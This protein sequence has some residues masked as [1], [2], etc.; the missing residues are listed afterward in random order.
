L[1]EGD[2]Q[3]FGIGMPIIAYFS[4]RVTDAST[5]D[6][7]VTVTVNGQ[8]ADGAWYWEPSSLSSEAMEAH[9]R[10]AQ[11]WPGHAVIKVNM[12]LAGLWAGPGLVFDD[13]LTLSM[14]TGPAHL[15]TIDG[16]A[17]VDTM[18]ITSDSD[19]VRTLRVSLGKS[20]TPTYLGT[21]LVMAKDNP[22][23]M[24]SAPGEEPAYRIEV[25]WSVRVTDDGEFIH[26]AYWNGQI[27]QQ[28]LSHG[29]TNLTPADAE[30]YYSWSLIGDP[31]TWINTGTS[32]VIPA[33]DGWGDWNL[34]WTT[35]QQ[36]GL[37][38]PVA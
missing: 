31:V 33:T 19:P 21:A 9:Y 27:G 14:N 1:F 20:S 38:S 26:D 35:W 12:P 36:G 24:V 29:C 32:A 13:S 11:Y 25:P 8:P 23:L 30:W 28:N 2:G 22:Q 37:L 5:F 7:A 10:A 18:T 34:P 4:R 17:G 6:K 3:T 16:T 15:V